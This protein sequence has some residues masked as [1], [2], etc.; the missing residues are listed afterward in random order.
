MK[1]WILIAAGLSLGFLSA[2]EPKKE[3][4]SQ[5]EY[6]LFQNYQK[7]DPKGKVEALDKWK[8]AFPASDF[9]DE[10]EE[11]YL[12]VYQRSNMNREAFDDPRVRE[13]LLRDVP[14][15]RTGRLDEVGPLVVYLASS[16][17]DYMTGQTV[18][19]DG[20]HSAA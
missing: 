18:F 14:A 7:A 6:N 11:E 16:A 12:L 20:G 9:A 13:R 15:R 1:N 19:L 8:A 17:P 3:W 4:K 10:R 5:E 2:Q